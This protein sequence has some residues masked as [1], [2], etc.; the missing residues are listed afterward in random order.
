MPHT[1]KGHRFAR[2]QGGQVVRHAIAEPDR[3]PMNGDAGLPRRDVA[4]V[5]AV[6]LGSGWQ[7]EGHSASCTKD[8]LKL[9]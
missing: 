9:R 4:F 5:C 7:V 2:L 1:P 3:R 8:P 6:Q